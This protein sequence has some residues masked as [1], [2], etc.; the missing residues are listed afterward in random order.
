MSPHVH[1]HGGRHENGGAGR[2]RDGGHE[3]VRQA[4]GELGQEVRGRGRDDQQLGPVCERDVIDL[5]LLGEVE[6]LRRDALAA[7]G[8]EHERR[9][10]LA[11][12]GRHRATHR[13]SGAGQCPDQLRDLVGRDAAAHGEKYAPPFHSST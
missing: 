6:Q 8:L 1:V 4:Q 10:E 7:Q 12:G 2:Q 5:A 9:D 3:I 13:A 11:G